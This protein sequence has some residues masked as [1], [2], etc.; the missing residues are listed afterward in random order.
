MATASSIIAGRALVLIEAIDRTGKVFPK[1]IARFKNFTNNV[2]LLML[3]GV[4]PINAFK[5]ALMFA[6]NP[7]KG[8]QYA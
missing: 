3:R 4:S 2:N 6:I 8:M 5:E 1:I 7:I